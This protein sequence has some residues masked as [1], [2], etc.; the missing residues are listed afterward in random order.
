M[1]KQSIIR[2]FCQSRADGVFFRDDADAISF[3]RELEFVYSETYDEEFPE[4]TMANGDIIP[5]DSTVPSGAHS[6]TYYSYSPTGLARVM[7]TY[8]S[9]SIPRVGLAAKKHTAEIHSVPLS[10][11]WNLQDRRAAEMPGQKYNLQRDKAFATKRTTMQVFDE[12]GW[13]GDEE[14]NLFGFL[15]HPNVTHTTAPVGATSSERSMLLKEPDE[16][17]ADFR[18]L[19]NTPRNLTKSVE[20]VTHVVVSDEVWADL[21]ARPRSATSDTSIATWL[22]AN[23]K[24][25]TF[26]SSA[27]LN[28]DAHDGTEFE[29]QSL[30]VAYQKRAGKGE[31]VIPQ[32][33]E[34]MPPQEE[35]LETVVY[36]HGRVGGVKQPYPLSVHVYRDITGDP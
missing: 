19:I 3:A 33:F 15:N 30:M 28:A 4:L 21:V 6:Y 8:A 35:G 17:L 10:Y 20:K 27:R 11:A 26:T 25:V 1:S 29:G 7:N 36:T 9:S 31:L 2:A 23:F 32:Q 14:H 16:I 34:Q 12:V 24:D 22:Q 18:D 13:F 5:I